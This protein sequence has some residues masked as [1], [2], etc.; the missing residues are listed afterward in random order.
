MTLDERLEIGV[1]SARLRDEG[2]EDEATE[3]EKTR[4]FPAFGGENPHGKSRL[5]QGLSP[6]LRLE[7]GGSGG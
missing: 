5:G 3:L 1:Q 2:K 4:L 7:Y 6:K